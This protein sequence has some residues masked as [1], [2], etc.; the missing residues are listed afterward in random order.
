QSPPT[1]WSAIEDSD[2]RQVIARLRAIGCPEQTIRDI[3]ALRVCRQFR[4]R[5]LAIES[6]AAR[7]RSYTRQDS[8]EDWRKR[9][10]QQRDI[11]DEMMSTLESL[12]G[13]SWEEVGSSVSG[14]PVFAAA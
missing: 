3:V 1:L 9:V 7:S 10:E 12:F 5:L 2:P 14:S 8:R 6:E 13:E 4:D 11:R